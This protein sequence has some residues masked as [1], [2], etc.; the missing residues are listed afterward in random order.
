MAALAELSAGSLGVGGQLRALEIIGEGGMG[1]IREAEQVTLGRVV[2]VKTLKPS[3]REAGAA[4]DLLREAWVTGSLEHPNVVPV[5]YLELDERGHPVIVLK[6]IAGVEW[7][8]LLY[9]AAAV[10]AR[11]GATDLLAWNLGILLQVLNAIR[12]AHSKGI[13]HRDLKPSN[14]MIG[15]YG[16]VYLL[17]WGIAVSLRDD[18]SGRMSLASNA[19]E[20]AGTPCYM[21]P[22]MLGRDNCPW[23]ISER[24]DV[25]LAG[26]VLFELITT[27]PPHDG[28]TALAV[29]ASVIASKPVLPAS[30]PPELAKICL[31]AMAEDPADRFESA[32]AMRV[33]IQSYLEHRGSANLCARAEL[34]LGELLEVVAHPISHL[35]AANTPAELEAA[36]AAELEQRET[37]YR[38]Y[39]A[40][41]FGCHE[42]LAVWRDNVDA[43]T[44][45]ARAT[46]SV[47]EYELATANPK[48]A[49]TLLGE[50]S[51]A[52]AELVARARQAADAEAR[53]QAELEK[54]RV[55][56][57]TVAGRRT[58]SALSGL[59]GFTFAVL[60]LLEA[61]FPGILPLGT[62]R[63][64]VVWAVGALVIVLGFVYWARH[65]FSST[66]FNRSVA[67]TGIFLF[68]GQI[69]VSA[70]SAQ[71]G[72]SVMQSQV[73]MVFFWG[74]LTS[75]VAITL[76]RW[77]AP[78]AAF[79]FA[80]FLFATRFP[81]QRF[82]AMAASNF[83]FG[84]N[85]LIRWRPATLVMSPDEKAWLERTKHNY[86]ARRRS[87]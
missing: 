41:R 3:R 12:F 4:L 75:M 7:S 13:V 77:L 60:P 33:A 18:R 40:C 74:T 22:E 39:G 80:A 47:A 27:K 28:P 1:V 71:L 81:E 73:A 5:H 32:D 70:G 16:E 51:D 55:Q 6:R 84:L 26:S 59:L 48:A 76:D 83:V 61:L 31:R 56:H 68:V 35:S 52:P 64:N 49:V 58:R 21:A 20:L 69:I 36:D 86:R 34:R 14:V 66:L 10:E 54:L 63:G 72:L 50:L 78:A 8:Q 23:P 17:D 65:T 37:V 57:D 25:Y 87:R 85:A 43:Q 53:H 79:Y 2:A 19:T 62:H 30:V 11:F 67:M 45:L 44:C 82:Y 24:T 46:I 29:I 38:L 15:D 42:A 9:D